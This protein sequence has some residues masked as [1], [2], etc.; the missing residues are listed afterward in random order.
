MAWREARKVWETDFFRPEGDDPAY[1]LLFPDLG[2]M[3]ALVASP[4]P[5]YARRLWMP[6]LPLLAE[7]HA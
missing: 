4:F 5:E 7:K 1:R 2:G 6:I 3:D